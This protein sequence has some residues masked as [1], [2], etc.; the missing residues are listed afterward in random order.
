[1]VSKDDSDVKDYSGTSGSINSS[2]SEQNTFDPG[3]V[4]PEDDYL[5]R[6]THTNK[7]ASNEN[8]FSMLSKYE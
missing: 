3:G 2:V 8:T 1:M 5:T 7:T 4:I 6:T